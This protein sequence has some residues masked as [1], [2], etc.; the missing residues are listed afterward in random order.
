M[1]WSYNNLNAYVSS[2]M[3]F[4]ISFDG[5]LRTSWPIQSLITL[6]NLL[7]CVSISIMA[8][9]CL[10]KVI[11]HDSICGLALS[12]LFRNFSS[13]YFSTC[14]KVTSLNPLSHFNFPKTH[15]STRNSTNLSSSLGVHTRLTTWCRIHSMFQKYKII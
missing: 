12:L 10:F 13:S 4:S 11:I 15:N 1:K 7:S 14:K 9:N 6:E 8:L 3:I 5:T 2:C